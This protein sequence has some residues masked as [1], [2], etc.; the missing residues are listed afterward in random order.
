M[1]VLG[2]DPGSRRTG[3][4]VVEAR[5]NAYTCLAHGPIVPGARL[6]LPQ[7]LEAIAAR[8]DEII[9]LHAPDCVCI[10][11]A[12]Y[13]ESVRSTLVL[14]HVRGALMLAA[15]R[16]GVEI[17]EYSPREIKMSVA[18]NGGASK[19]QVEFMVM[20][21][22]RTLLEPPGRCRGRAGRGALSPPPRRRAACRRAALRRPRRSSPRC[23]RARG[24]DDRL[25]ART[26]AG[27]FGGRGRDRGGRRRLRRQR[28]DSHPRAGCRPTG[29]E[30]FLRTRQVVREDALLL[31][32]FLEEDELR[33]FDLLLGVSGVGPRVALA[34]LSGLRVARAGARHSR[35]EHR[36]AGGRSGDRAKNR[37]AAGGRVARQDGRVRAE[38]G[39]WRRRPALP[40]AVRR[41]CRATRSSKTP[42]RRS[43]G[44]ATLRPRRRRS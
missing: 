30:V 42:S 21:A 33:L 32:G 7:R 38:R 28:L 1:R 35:R 18:G 26:P 43:R 31:F 4:G 20:P 40:R 11:E 23:W 34:V 36:G 25:A 13:H 37:R 14:G 27:A 9:T 5:G 3:F 16:R 8:V 19:E 44:W 15:V 29:A 41:C 22:A 17:A 39:A 2:L 24:R 6:G 10:E 12:F